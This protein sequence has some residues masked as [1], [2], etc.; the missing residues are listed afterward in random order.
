MGL[1]DPG[2]RR[3]DCF[4]G[5]CCPAAEGTGLSPYQLA[6]GPN[7]KR[8][9]YAYRLEHPLNLSALVP[10]DQKGGPLSGNE[11]ADA[12]FGA[13][14]DAHRHDAQPALAIRLMNLLKFWK[15]L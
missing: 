10:A 14:I 4:A 12:T 9:W 2:K 11:L 7:Q 6:V 13:L 15:F 5:V 3:V 8:F 1:V